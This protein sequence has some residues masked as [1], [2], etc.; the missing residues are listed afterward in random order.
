MSDWEDYDAEWEEDDAEWEHEGAV[1]IQNSPANSLTAAA[2]R[3]HLMGLYAQAMQHKR[4]VQAADVKHSRLCTAVMM[5]G[6][7][8]AVGYV[9]GKIALPIVNK[10]LICAFAA[11]CIRFMSLKWY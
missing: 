8:A 9:C 6:L 7:I 10:V 11:Y 5:L 2:D 1:C 3:R 4:T